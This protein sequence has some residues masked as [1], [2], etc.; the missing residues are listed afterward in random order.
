MHTTLEVKGQSS[1]K[2][3]IYKPIKHVLLF[4]SVKIKFIVL[5]NKNTIIG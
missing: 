5:L 3:K 1:L 2:R 4:V